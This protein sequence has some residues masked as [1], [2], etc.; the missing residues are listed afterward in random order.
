MRIAYRSETSV[1]AVRRFLAEL[2]V[3]GGQWTQ[4]S[5][6]DAELGASQWRLGEATLTQEIHELEG[7]PRDGNGYSLSLMARLPMG[8]QIVVQGNN[9][10]RRFTALTFELT[11]FSPS[12][13]DR[14]RR[15]GATHFGNDDTAHPVWARTNARDIEGAG[16]RALARTLLTEALQYDAPPFA[17]SAV[18]DVRRHLIAL[19][20]DPAAKAELESNALFHDPTDVDGLAAVASGAKV[21]PNWD[22][23]TAATI[24]TYLRPWTPEAVARLK[25]ASDAWA[26]ATRQGWFWVNAQAHEVKVVDG[27]RVRIA[28]GPLI[29]AHLPDVIEAVRRALALDPVS[30]YLPGV[31]AEK[32]DAREAVLVGD[33]PKAIVYR[34]DAA[35]EWVWLWTSEPLRGAVLAATRS[36]PVEIQLCWL[37]PPPE[38]FERFVLT[39]C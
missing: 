34:R 30:L 35:L 4:T 26:G 2:V 27:K 11:G 12:Q 38:G 18:R 1:D 39:P 10:E 19:T 21:L 9:Y 8:R 3:D 36:A 15:L 22:P 32:A 28:H 25:P 13:F 16:D 5:P 14:A 33:Q 6:A 7:N 37:G 17:T 23:A 29:P 20:D 31:P 24:L